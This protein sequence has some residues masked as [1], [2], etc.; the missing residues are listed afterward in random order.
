MGRLAGRQIPGW[1]GGN[2]GWA[3]HGLLHWLGLHGLALDIE[4]PRPRR[5]LRVGGEDMSTDWAIY[6]FD[7]QHARFGRRVRFLS[8]AGARSRRKLEGIAARM[9]ASGNYVMSVRQVRLV[10]KWP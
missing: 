2:D 4:H 3:A 1:F 5:V 7:C 10:R 9:N 8:F 6:G